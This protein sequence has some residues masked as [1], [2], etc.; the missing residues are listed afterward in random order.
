VSV[1]AGAGGDPWH[2]ARAAIA[3]LPPELTRPP[4]TARVGA[5]LVLLE[6]GP[7][8]PRLVLTRRRRDLRSHPGQ[9]AFP[10]GRVDPGET[11]EAAALREAAEEVGLDP[12]SV[13]LVGRGP[14]FHVPPSRF[15][16]V[17]VLARWTA[18]HALVPDPAEVEAVLGVDLATL[19]EEATWRHTPVATRG[20]SAWAWQLDGDLLWGATA[21]VVRQLLDV[22]HPGWDGGRDAAALG[23]ERAVEPWLDAPR[24]PR[25]TVLVP[26]SPAR[27]QAGLPHVDAAAVRALRAHLAAVGVDAQALAERSGARLA[28]AALRLIADGD[29]RATSGA[30][31][32]VTVLAGPSSDGAGGHAAA[33]VLARAGLEVVVLQV[34]AARV[35]ALGDLA[36]SAGARVID[37]RADGLDE[38]RDPGRLVVDALLGVGG[39][40]PLEG[41]VERVA[42]W[43]RRHDVRVLASTLPSGVLADRGIAGTCLSADVTV[44]LGLPLV[45]HRAASSQPFLGDLRLADVG[46]TPAR[47]REVGVPD[48]PEDL[49]AEGPLVRLTAEAVEGDAGTPL[50]TS[51]EPAV[52]A[53][54]LE[55]TLGGV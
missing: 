53:V 35:P 30:P 28:E 37:S 9:V 16:V 33:A 41:E 42:R 36:R 5:V 39:R 2:R 24:G 51:D 34:G 23:L 13:E 6:D 45:A 1:D 46:V 14:T 47:W 48:V 3:A 18:P 52:R 4:A 12:A 38:H 31:D 22:V 32:R 15:W 29:G 11:I 8:G 44:A 54:G 43:L 7:A 49:F 40:S 27:E 19:T 17:P 21:L 25:R 26:P 50:Q 20:G 55:P 10:G